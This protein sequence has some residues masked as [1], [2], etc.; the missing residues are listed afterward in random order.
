MLVATVLASIPVHITLTKERV[1]EASRDQ[2]LS[3]VNEF[4]E[5]SREKQINVCTSVI[6]SG[7]WKGRGLSW[8]F[9]NRGLAYFALQDFDHAFADFNEA[10]RLDPNAS[11]ARNNRGTVYMLRDDADRAM[12][13]FDEAIKLDPNSVLAHR[14]RAVMFWDKGDYE[15]AK[16]DYGETIR[17]DPEDRRHWSGGHTPT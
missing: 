10:I 17:L 1:A 6:A 8:A 13:D 3:C 12:A 15:R 11:M 5:L 9:S 4:G 2:V 7:N 16:A 14:N